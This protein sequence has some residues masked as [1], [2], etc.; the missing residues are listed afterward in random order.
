[1]HF[2]KQLLLPLAIALGALAVFE[3]GSRYGAA[4]TRAL[5]IAETM[6]RTRSLYAQNIQNTPEATQAP[7]ELT[8]LM[9]HSLIQGA[10]H[11]QIWYLGKKPK[12][13]LDNQ[14]TEALNI[15]GTEFFTK[16]EQI[17]ISEAEA[18]QAEKFAKAIIYLKND[19]YTPATTE[20]TKPQ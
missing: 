10:M 2:I 5:S 1:M 11:R 8:L 18:G 15:Y 9:D 16:I 13:I 17:E 14:L 12:A 6:G 4:N 19:L 3:T 20:T 7:K